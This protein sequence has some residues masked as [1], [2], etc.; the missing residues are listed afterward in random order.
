MVTFN[1]YGI[2][3]ARVFVTVPPEMDFL[4]ASRP[5]NS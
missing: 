3:L 2:L 1:I 4:Q 5:K